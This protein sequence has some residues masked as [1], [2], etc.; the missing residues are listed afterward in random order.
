MVF[1]RKMVIV[2]RKDL[3]MSSGKITVQAAHV[4]VRAIKKASWCDEKLWNILYREKKVVLQ[5]KDLEELW[6]IRDQ[7]KKAKLNYAMVQDAGKTEIAPGE[8]TAIAIG[9]TRSNKIDEITGQLK[10]L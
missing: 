3:E 8:W 10:L 5:V 1:E 4:A 6:K 9:P 2:V 7:C